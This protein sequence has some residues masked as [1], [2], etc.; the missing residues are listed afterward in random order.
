MLLAA[1]VPVCAVV[2]SAPAGE[3]QTSAS[4]VDFTTA[5]VQFYNDRVQ[6]LLQA[7]CYKCHSLGKV[8]GGLRLTSRDAIL[9]GGDSG[10]AVDLR[11]IDAS[12]LLE[13]VNYQSYEMPPG[14]KLA[15]E[16]IAILRQW[17]EKGLP[18]P[19]AGESQLQDDK[20]HQPPQVNDETRRHWAFQPVERPPV[21]AVKNGAW[22]AN[23]ID[24][25]ILARLEQ[26]G[27][28]PA[29]P[30]DP[31]ALMRRVTYDLTGLPPTPEEVDAF[32][33][34]ES[35]DAYEKLVER[36]LN[37]PHYGEQGARAWLDLVRYAESNSFERDNPKPYVWRY[38]DYVIRSLNNDKPYDQFIRE[39]LAGDELDEITPESIIATG[40]YRLGLWDDEPADPLLAFYDGLDDIAATTAQ[41]FLG[42]TLNCARCH[43]HKL[44][45]IP[46][47]D[48][49]RFTA[50]FRNIRHYGKR[51]DESVVE[52]SV[53]KVVLPE[54]AA[55]Y[56][57]QAADYERHVSELAAQIR[58]TEDKAMPLLEGGE[59]DDFQDVSSRL[60]I[61]RRGVGRLLDE[62]AFQ[63]YERNKSTL[64]KL[65]ADPPQAISLV[66]AV[67]EQ[68]AEPAPTHVLVRGNPHVEGDEVVPGFP[69]VLSAPDP[70]IQR[71]AHNESS[72]RRRALADWI[73]APGNPLT[74]R[75]MINRIWQ[76]HFGRG[77]VR[78]PN[79]FGLQGTAPTHPELLDWLAAEF[80][81]RGWSLKAMH[82][83]ILMSNTYRMSSRG[84]SGEITAEGGEGRGESKHSEAERNGG[85][86]TAPISSPRLD[87]SVTFET[88]TSRSPP[89]SGLGSPPSALSSPLAADPQNDLFS[90]FDMRRLRA[91]EVRDSMLAV[92]GSLNTAKRFG[93]SIYPAI[94]PE[95][96]AGQS[97]PGQG[98][99]ASSDED[100]RRRSIYIHIKRSLSVPI[101]ASFDAP[102]TDFTCP[103]R[104]AT[105][106]P[107]QALGM[108]NSTFL[109]EQARIL[110]AFAQRN[111]GDDRAAQVRLVLRRVTQRGPADR[112]VARGVELRTAL[113]TEHGWSEKASLEAFCLTAFNLN[114]F[115]YL[116]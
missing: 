93:P 105:T 60:D 116:D 13:A 107:T 86:D 83:L 52:A 35:L 33:A 100:V 63:Q 70:I 11:E 77:I 71:P 109:S 81:A 39:Q 51:S 58:R 29:P 45:P 90:R 106:Q 6:P 94:P 98:W 84:E 66:L 1:V 26:A 37:S 22:V 36:L 115:L 18:L 15:E 110:A 40:F 92:N 46:Q 112:D 16:Q 73:A 76:G 30:A 48:Y 57:R 56:E 14:G 28:T 5:D 64:A 9:Q 34:D 3:V 88:P 65:E 27:L 108:L 72:G 2:P 61:L 42:L 111:A 99:G 113:E 31:Q 67:K 103:V 19:A 17:V 59:K 87:A 55:D 82:R 104:F 85:S 75:V 97:R 43:D 23:P 4:N 53:R 7:H 24:A 47:V 96:L 62:A 21:P 44:D 102:D 79:N 68:G 41:A 50:F 80:V 49:Y 54:E 12:L 10:P 114:E 38:R 25:F 78:S 74:A 91:E 32:V 69:A 101:L 20:A 89:L 95:V 8:K